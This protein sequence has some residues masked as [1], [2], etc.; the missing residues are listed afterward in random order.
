MPHWT[1]A[2]GQ[3]Y[4][5][6]ERLYLTV[7]PQEELKSMTGDRED[8]AGLISLLPPDPHQEKPQGQVSKSVLTTSHVEQT[9]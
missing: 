4:H 6:L 8:L 1:D 7:G 2:P 9:H 5:L 3:A